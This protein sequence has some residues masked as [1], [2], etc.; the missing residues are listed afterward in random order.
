MSAREDAASAGVIRDLVAAGT[1]FVALFLVYNANGREIGSFDTQPTKFAARELLLRHTLALNHV[2]GATPQYAERWGFIS[3]A[4]G[5]YRS[6]YSPVSSLMA[7]G[8]TWPLWKTGIVDIRAPAA[9]A[10]MAKL[11]A[12]LLIAL[13]AVLAFF[14]ARA[15]L[16][17]GPAVLVASGLGLGTGFWSTASQTLWQTETSTL[18]LMIAVLAFAGTRDAL[19]LRRAVA[20]GVGLGL[21]GV[22]RPQ[23]APVVIVL[24]AG[25]SLRTSRLNAI[26]ATAIIAVC[27]AALVTQNL[28]WFGHA[29]GALPLLQEQNAIVHASGSSFRLS[30]E[31]WLGLLVSPSRGLLIFSPIVLVAAAGI[32]PAIEEGWRAPLRWC[33][34]AATAQ[35]A[36]YATYSVWWGGHTYGPR[37]LLDILPLLVP[38]AA[39][40]LARLP[41]SPILRAAGALALAWSVLVAATGAFSYP[42]DQWNVV[43]SDVDRNHARLW[44]WSDMQIVRCWRTGFSGQNFALFDRGAVRVPRRR[45]S[46]GRRGYARCGSRARGPTPCSPSSAPG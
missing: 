5:R 33:V 24:L 11:T 15:Y 2:V 19:G 35:Y 12:S 27:A 42:A 8:V 41:H 34:I 44:S 43:P 10:L 3:A 23:L 38:P 18:G 26:A 28:R 6:I 14:A 20:I 13:S 21:A 39:A 40:G 31:G 25:T 45:A 4:D 37:Y 7:A 1:L 16:P 30:P 32:R 17:R 36:L 22:T 46:A 29:L 9:P